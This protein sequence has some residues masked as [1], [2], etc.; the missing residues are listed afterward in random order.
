MAKVGIIIPVFNMAHLLEEGLNSI[1]NQ[2]LEDIEII[3]INDCSTDNSLDILYKYQ[4]QDPRFVIINLEQNKGTGYAR[5]I[6]IENATADYIMF[7]DPDDLYVK[8]ACEK[9]YNKIR[10]N[11]DD[12]VF[13]NFDCFNHNGFYKSYFREYNEMLPSEIVSKNIYN[14]NI[15]YMGC[16]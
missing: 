2:T 5:N 9:A 4:K 10:Q 6:G 11:D 12:I 7:F 16:C 15:P 14:N 1:R 13:F 8:E 3:C